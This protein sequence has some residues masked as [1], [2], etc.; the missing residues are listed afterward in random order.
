MARI[1]RLE[2]LF[3]IPSLDHGGPDRVMFEI[4]CA[5]DR[6][7][8]VPRLMVGAAGGYYAA[9]LPSDVSIEVIGGGRY[10]LVRALRA[11]RRLSPDIVF[12][13]LRMIQTL[14]LG[15]PLFRRRTKLIV[16]QATHAS[17]DWEALIASAR[18]KHTVSRA[19]TL[20]ALR[21]AD[22][23][24]CQS[25]AMKDDM[26]ALLGAAA[27]LQVVPNPIDVAAVARAAAIPAPIRGTPALI[28][29]GRFA[30]VKGYDLLLGAMPAILAAHP[31][32]HLTILG[33]SSERAAHE[34]LA[35]ELGVAEAVTFAGFDAEPLP[36]VRAADLF[37]LASR[38]EGFPNAALEA[39]ACGTPIVLTGCPGGNGQLVRAGFNGRLSRAVSSA[40]FSEAVCQA[41]A[42]RS[43][44]DR[45]AIADD[46]GRRYGARQVV[47]AY[48]RLFERVARQTPP[49]VIADE[50]PRVVG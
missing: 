16:R 44:Y 15:Q 25:E 42:E 48:E 45:A 21:R 5:L 12:G 47:A 38:Y 2:I 33:D 35:R 30:R 24:V 40:S 11:V 26:R 22:A 49:S 4:L 8:F 46:C 3:A 14:G 10:P 32:A 34:Q 29:V 50:S 41:L 31:A 9:R 28:S 18:L 20:A 19:L 27:D 1:N 43:Q 6:K 39:V 36:K 13:T 37:V 7:R 17:T 23:I